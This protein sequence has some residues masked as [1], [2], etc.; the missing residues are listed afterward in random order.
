MIL[1]SIHESLCFEVS[2]HF[3]IPYLFSGKQLLFFLFPY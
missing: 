2:S 3:G 1:L